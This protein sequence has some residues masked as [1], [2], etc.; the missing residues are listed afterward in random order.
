MGE[1]MMTHADVFVRA[2]G[3]AIEEPEVEAGAG[4]LLQD[5]CLTDAGARRLRDLAVRGAAWGN[6]IGRLSLAAL[7]EIRRLRRIN[8]SLA[9]QATESS[10]LVSSMLLRLEKLNLQVAELRERVRCSEQ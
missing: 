7:L 6:Q 10:M 4:G 5:R 3:P 9:E 1:V 2:F 8:A